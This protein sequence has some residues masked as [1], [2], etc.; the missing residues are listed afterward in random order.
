MKN[1]AEKC[2]TEK[3]F[4]PGDW[5]FV[6]L[7]PYR[8]Q[9]VAL[10]LNQKLG[11]RFFGPFKV[12]EKVGIVAYKLELPPA[13][14]IHPVFHVSNLKKC[15]GNPGTQTIPLPLMTT[16]GAAILQPT[17]ILNYRHLKRQNQWVAQA[18]VQWEGLPLEEASW[19]DIAHL[20]HL[21]PH[22]ILE[23]KVL[24]EEDGN[25]RY[26]GKG[27]DGTTGTDELK[28]ESPGITTIRK[29]MRPRKRPITL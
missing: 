5:V 9:S 15:V 17:A 3:I 28:R 1:Q 13:A 4:E 8:Q 22:L 6:K 27:E 19:E 23:D 26:H 14:H 20:W 7:Q 29:S 16:D 18:L 11:R 10:R 12:L 2:R 25:D 21:Y 24:W